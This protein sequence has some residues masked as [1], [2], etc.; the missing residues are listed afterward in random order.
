M[1]RTFTP[2]RKTET[3]THIT[4]HRYCDGC[5]RD[6]GDATREEL[7]AAIAGA[8]LPSVVEECGCLHATQQLALFM[9]ARDNGESGTA[10]WENLDPAGQESYANEAASIVHAMVRLGWAPVRS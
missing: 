2:P 3:G 9:N 7:D 10:L 5:N 8:R 6:V 1:T 4:V